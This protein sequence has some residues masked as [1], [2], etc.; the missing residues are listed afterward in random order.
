M[1]S[2]NNNLNAI[3]SNFSIKDLENISGIKAHTIRIWEKRYNVLQPSRSETNIRLYSNES[4]L[5]LLNISLLYNKGIKISK[6]SQM[7]EVEIQNKVKTLAITGDKHY[8]TITEL[9]VAMFQF[10]IFLLQ[11][12]YDDLL[13]LNS[14]SEIFKNIFIPFFEELGVLWQTT[15]LLP[16]HEH[17]VSNFI[18]QKIQSFT[19]KAQ[20][21]TSASSITYV[22]YLPE[23]EIHELGLLYLNYELILN[24]RT[25]IY[26]GQNLPIQNLNVFKDNAKE[27][28]FVTSLTVRPFTKELSPYFK[29]IEDLLKNSRHRFVAL[30][31]KAMEMKEKKFKENIRVLPSV[32]SFLNF[33]K[34]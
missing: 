23:N 22:L 30:G 27:I 26:L 14:F 11:K 28:C 33:L 8:N 31:N 18:M 7:S 9:K 13:V 6:I 12:I 19:E 20:R 29:E 25:T 17:F 34:I 16:A 21:K 24:G 2:E 10:D 3:Q 32:V 4:L 5:K 1:Q 15:S